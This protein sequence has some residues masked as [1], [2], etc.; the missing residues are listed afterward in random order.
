MRE[1]YWYHPISALTSK[2][3][4]TITRLILLML[5]CSHRYVAVAI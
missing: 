5:C 4:W 3:T 1:L 2:I